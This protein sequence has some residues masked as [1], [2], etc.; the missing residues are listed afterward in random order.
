M[1]VWKICTVCGT[2]NPT[3]SRCPLHPRRKRNGSTRAYRQARAIVLRYA[4]TCAI[5]GQP[6][7]AD[8]R[9]EADHIIPKSKGGP[10]HPSNLRAVHRSCNLARGNRELD[11]APGGPVDGV[12]TGQRGHPR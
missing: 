8:D 12:P 10:D 1:P 6:E 11:P 9:L 7:R 5:C 4:L 2:P 3:G